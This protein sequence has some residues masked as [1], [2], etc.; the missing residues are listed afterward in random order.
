MIQQQQQIAL[1]SLLQ[2]SG[3]PGSMNLA[4]LNPLMIQQN[5]LSHQM[6]MSDDDMKRGGKPP[7]GVMMGSQPLQPPPSKSAQSL[8]SD[9]L[10]NGRTPPQ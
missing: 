2:G 3:V 5:M 9:S 4:G 7:V 8:N 1:A 10:S 6:Q